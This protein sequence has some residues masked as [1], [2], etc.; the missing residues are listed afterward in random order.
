MTLD[1]W[2]VGLEPVDVVISVS[3]CA[4]ES[5]VAGGLPIERLAVVRNGSE[6]PR[7]LLAA[8]AARQRPTQPPVLLTP[9]RFT[10]HAPA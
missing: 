9:A 10:A 2:R 4:G 6:P 5:L 3:A 8:G 1:E 7:G